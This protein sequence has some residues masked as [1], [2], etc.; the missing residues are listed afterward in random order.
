MTHSATGAD[1]ELHGDVYALARGDSN[2]RTGISILHP[3]KKFVH[4]AY[5]DVLFA[6]MKTVLRREPRVIVNLPRAS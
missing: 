4:T 2:C 3:G 1:R 6:L 5:L